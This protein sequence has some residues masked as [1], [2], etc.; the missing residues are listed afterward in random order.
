MGRE[1][2]KAMQNK[3]SG[4][5]LQTSSN[6]LKEERFVGVGGWYCVNMY[7]RRTIGEEQSGRHEVG[8]VRS[9]FS[10]IIDAHNVFDGLT[11]CDYTVGQKD[12]EP[13]RVLELTFS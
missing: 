3:G 8:Q 5:E 2:S 9:H 12:R 7:S 11:G 13:P 4:V 1:Q 10:K 6:A